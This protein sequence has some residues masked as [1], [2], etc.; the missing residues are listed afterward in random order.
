MTRPGGSV[1]RL[2][3]D[4]VTKSYGAQLVLNDVSLA[5]GPQTRIG[6]VGPNGVGKS[7]LL[8]ILA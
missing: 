4:G 8:R 2:S 1:T 5:V 3:L 7:T 6:L